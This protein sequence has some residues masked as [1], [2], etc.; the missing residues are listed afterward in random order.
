MISENMI[1]KSLLTII[2]QSHN[3][4]SSDKH[5]ASVVFQLRL[6]LVYNLSFEGCIIGCQEDRLFVNSRRIYGRI[7]VTLA[8]VWCGRIKNCF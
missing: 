1:T 8:F 6:V 7:I 3:C 4:I 2:H 5:K